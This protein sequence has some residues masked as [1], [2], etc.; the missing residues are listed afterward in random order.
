MTISF[1]SFQQNTL[2]VEIAY[3]FSSS[4]RQFV[5]CRIP[6]VTPIKISLLF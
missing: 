2:N 3:Y 6:F 1:A 5:F 4:K